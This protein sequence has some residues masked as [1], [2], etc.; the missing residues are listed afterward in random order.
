MKTLRMKFLL[1]AAGLF[2][3]LPL[4]AQVDFGGKLGAGMSNMKN[5][6]PDSKARIGIQAGLVARFQL[7]YSSFRTFKNYIQAELVY[8]AQGEKNGK[9]EQYVDYLTLPVMYKYYLTDNDADFFVEAGPQFSYAINTNLEPYKSHD[10]S[11]PHFGSD[12][13]ILNKFDV[14]FNGGIG[15]S[16]QRK[17]ELNLRYSL[18]LMDTFDYKYKDNKH[19]RSSF[20][21]FSMIYFFNTYY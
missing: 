1:I 16:F 14:A 20:L 3:T 17:F 7:E 10:P 21:S 13:N 12:N 18:G 15:Y 19:N 4:S 9:Y 11:K 2:F 5:I 6:F 8:S